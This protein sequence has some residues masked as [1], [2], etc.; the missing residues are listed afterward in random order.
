MHG[1][2][3]AGGIPRATYRLQLNRTF[4]LRDASAAGW[5]DTWIELPR[6]GET[7]MLANVL[8]GTGVQI[9]DVG[10][11]CGIALSEVLVDFPVALLMTP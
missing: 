9:R 6:G 11:R 1:G 8:D 5:G 2:E 4:T 3:R 7:R 10:G